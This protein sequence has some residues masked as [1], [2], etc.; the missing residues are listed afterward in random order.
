MK[1]ILLGVGF[2]LLGLAGVAAFAQD[3]S[4]VQNRVQ[5]PVQEPIKVPVKGAVPQV[6]A[7]VL[8]A[9]LD[10]A[11]GKE[12]ADSTVK[13]RPAPDLSQADKPSGFLPAEKLREEI[14][15]KAGIDAEI[16]D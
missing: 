10:E 1:H 12:F 7:R 5:E 14:F 16:S 13:F 4:P 6:E 11:A 2:G 15:Q 8:E 9:E 3:S